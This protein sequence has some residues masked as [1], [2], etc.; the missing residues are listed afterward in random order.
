MWWRSHFYA[1]FDLGRGKSFDWWST[2]KP[3]TCYSASHRLVEATHVD[4]GPNIA[5]HDYIT[6]FLCIPF[7]AMDPNSIRFPVRVL[8]RTR[9][10]QLQ[11][12]HPSLDI[13]DT[14]L[15]K[16]ICAE[17]SVADESKISHLIT[18]TSDEKRNGKERVD[19][20]FDYGVPPNELQPQVVAYSV[21]FDGSVLTTKL[22]LNPLY[23]PIVNRTVEAWRSI[24]L[25]YGGSFPGRTDVRRKRLAFQEASLV[26]NSK[27]IVTEILHANIFIEWKLHCSNLECYYDCQM[28]ALAV[29]NTP[30]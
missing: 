7:W 30:R 13:A 5:A 25:Q 17:L 9:P 16:R 23:R 8:I 3:H 11:K 1:K 19:I 15:I 2:S 20:V 22:L 27:S 4:P 24:D 26:G 18:R 10:S 14:I 21:K 12:I 29:E 6:N 28:L